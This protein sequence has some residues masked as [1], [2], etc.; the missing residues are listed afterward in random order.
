M[1]N[2]KSYQFGLFAEKIAIFFLRLKGYKILA[3]R[4]KNRFGEIDIVAKK[5]RIIV[6]IEVKARKSK[7]IIEEV[8]R[9]KQIERVKKSAEF[10]ISQNPQF[11]NYDLRFDFIEI[12]RFFFPKHYQNFIS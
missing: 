8:L 9:P 6:I 1:L 7:I 3:W 2:V 10:F 12:N 11:Q 4:F 5:S